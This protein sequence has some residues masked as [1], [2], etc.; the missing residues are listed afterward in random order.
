MRLGGRMAFA[1]TH[2]SMVAVGDTQLQCYE[3]GTG[4]PVLMVSGW[5][6]SALCWEKIFRLLA[7]DYRLIAVEP[8]ALGLSGP[9]SRYDMQSVAALFHALVPKLGFLRALF[10]GHAVA[11]RIGYPSSAQAPAA[12][13]GWPLTRA[14][15]PALQPAGAYAFSAEQAKKTW[16]FFFNCLPE[17]PEEL[18]AGRE[19]IIL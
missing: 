16:H 6:Q 1:N 10:V 5:P 11:P 15:V 9:T 17:L 12:R 8:P 4:D 13:R 18:T 2:P 19:Q 3:S 14:Q 7:P